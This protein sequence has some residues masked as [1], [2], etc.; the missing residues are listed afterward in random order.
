MSDAIEKAKLALVTALRNVSGDDETCS[1]LFAEQ[2][3]TFILA[4]LAAHHPAPAQPAA[5]GDEFFEAVKAAC[6]K[7]DRVPNTVYDL[8][9]F[10]VD[11]VSIMEEEQARRERERRRARG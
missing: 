2:L 11:I 5:T 1:S 3:S 4:H 7:R 9:D 8:E 6:D 10:A